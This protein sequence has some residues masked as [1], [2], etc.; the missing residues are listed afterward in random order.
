M[1]I[2]I[3]E[4]DDNSRVLLEVV[5]QNLG[6]EVMSFK[7]GKQALKY[8]QKNLVHAIISDILMPEMDGFEFC[9]AV[10]QNPVLKNIPFIFY[11]AT[12]TSSE[13]EKLARSLGAD[14]FAVKPMSP[15]ELLDMLS[16][17]ID[18]HDIDKSNLKVLNFSPLLTE[19]AISNAHLERVGIKLDKKIKELEEERRKLRES[20]QRFRDFAESSGDWL[21][22]TGV[23]LMIRIISETD[24]KIKPYS[25]IE[26][27]EC[28]YDPNSQDLSGIIEQKKRFADF[29]IEYHIKN[30]PTIYLRLSGKPIFD[31]KGIFTGYRGVGSNVTDRVMLAERV[32]F[33]ASHDELTGLPNRNTL[34][35]HLKYTLN[36]AERNGTQVAVLFIDLDNFKII[37]DTLGHTAGDVLLKGVSERLATRARA[38]DMLGRLGGDEFLMVIENATPHDAHGIATELTYMFIKPFD[39]ADQHVYSSASIGLSIFPDDAQSAEAMIN[40]ADLAMYRAKDNG[41]NKFE[42]Y[43]AEMSDAMHAWLAID[44]GLRHA[45]ESDEL[46][47]EYQPQINIRTG[48]I[49]GVEALVRWR[50]PIRGL[51]FPDLFIHIA[52]QSNLIILLG[53]WVINQVFA[54]LLDWRSHQCDMPR[55][56]INISAKHL[57]SIH[58]MTYFERA[59]VT[60]GELQSNICVEVTE[61]AMLE[62][63]PQVR[64]NMLYLQ[65]RGFKVSLDDFGMGHSSLV[66]LR[67]YAVQEIKIDKSFV[68]TLESNKEDNLIVRAIIALAKALEI[69]IIAE[70]VETMQQSEILL[71]YDC[72]YAQGYYYSR[73]VAAETIVVLSQQTYIHN[74]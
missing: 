37:N 34:Q 23:D 60:Y 16:L 70:G 49:I 27:S 58:F 11:T 3:A 61:H 48:Q 6:V 12:Y 28:G 66:Y 32:Q 59:I 29:V 21:W 65:T 36:R 68:A 44:T 62:D 5:L 72:H 4:D 40:A 69:E 19:R 31:T 14:H 30:Q 35:M 7:N 57:Q 26:L 18:E 15:E 55:V 8:L 25:L 13:D 63:L 52:E 73:P 20:E 41:K 56:S 51:L 10:K 74:T 2:L 47:L 67:R 45:I 64:D 1:K 38:T 43:T 22:E 24:F 33:L 50:H 53:E 54:Q 17:V 46:F 42:F 71:S 39:I 9:R